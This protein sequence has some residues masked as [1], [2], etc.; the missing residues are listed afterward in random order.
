MTLVACN[1]DSTRHFSLNRFVPLLLLFLSI[2]VYAGNTNIES[3]A[4]IKAE[5]T[6]H[7]GD[8]QVFTEGDIISFLI[9]LSHDAYIRIIYQ[10]AS[11]NLIQLAPNTKSKNIHYPAGDFINIPDTKNNF[12]F[13]VGPP[14][15]KETLWL[16]ASTKPQKELSGKQL[17]NGL[18]LLDKKIETIKLTL[19]DYAKS[20]NTKLSIA[21]TTIHTKPG[22]GLIMR[23]PGE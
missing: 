12:L 11:N 20:K 17:N 15:G 7:L 13:K 22:A 2:T 19:L 14:F 16:F 4:T 9:N 1:L 18:I 5:I 21:T 23:T 8:N 10:D 6:T 3:T